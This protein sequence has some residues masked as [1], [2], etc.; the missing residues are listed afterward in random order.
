MDTATVLAA[1]GAA[2]VMVIAWGGRSRRRREGGFRFVYVNQD[3]TA[4]E[5]SP[6][7]RTYLST[8]FEGADSGRP[9]VKMSY[10]S[11]DGWGSQSGFIERHRVPSRIVIEQVNPD[12]DA[13]EKQFAPD[14]LD[15]HRASGDSIVKNADGSVT[16]T[17]DPSIS[18]EERFNRAR[19]YVLSEQRLREE[20]ARISNDQV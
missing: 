1:V 19:S 4:R 11:R 12:Y 5:L 14:I 15:M 13:L 8:V 2:I 7:E 6:A 16:C 18:G 9:S 17:P 10:E 3:G 20:L